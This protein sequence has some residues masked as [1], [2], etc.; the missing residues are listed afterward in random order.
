M[1]AEQR[2]C[3]CQKLVNKLERDYRQVQ[4]QN[5]Q[6]LVLTRILRIRVEEAEKKI[7]EIFRKA[8][9]LEEDEADLAVSVIATENYLYDHHRSLQR[10]ED[11]FHNLNINASGRNQEITYAGLK[12]AAIR[13]LGSEHLGLSLKQDD[14][15]FYLDRHVLVDL[16]Y[17]LHID[18]SLLPGNCKIGKEVLSNRPRQ[19]TCQQGIPVGEISSTLKDLVSRPTSRTLY[20]P[21]ILELL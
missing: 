13:L 19:D 15:G 21:L 8:K 4:K 9:A 14:E 7:S 6:L 5:E 18:P 10:L 1:S 12:S 16:D 11:R 20:I 2:C 17:G 3:N